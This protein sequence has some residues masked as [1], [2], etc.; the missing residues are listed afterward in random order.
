MVQLLVV[1]FMIV[2]FGYYTVI[3]TPVF[4]R[5]IESATPEENLRRITYGI[6]Y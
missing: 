5:G 2:G 6:Y 1:G 4:G 3:L